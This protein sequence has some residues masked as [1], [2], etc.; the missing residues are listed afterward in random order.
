MAAWPQADMAP[1]AFAATCYPFGA[2]NYAAIDDYM[3]ST[4][5]ARLAFPLME[6]GHSG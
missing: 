6:L 5:K 1:L 3:P 4:H 2:M